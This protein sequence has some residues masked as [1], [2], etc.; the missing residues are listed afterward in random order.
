MLKKKKTYHCS[1]DSNRLQKK[2]EKKKY[3]IWYIEQY[4][5]LTHTL[6]LVDFGLQGRRVKSHQN[7]KFVLGGLGYFTGS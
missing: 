2:K 6:F 4:K 1:I 7:N 3:L 5:Y